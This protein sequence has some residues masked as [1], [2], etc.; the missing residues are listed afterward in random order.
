RG[1]EMPM[2][3]RFAV[4][5]AAFALLFACSAQAAWV[6]VEP[7]DAGFSVFFPAT[8]T[9]ATEQKPRVVTRI[10]NARAGKLICLIGVSDYDAHVEAERELELDMQNFLKQ[11][12]ATAT[13]Q[14][15]V[16]FRDA[17]DGPL[18]ALKFSFSKSG[19]TGQSLVVVAG[20]RSY[21]AAAI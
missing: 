8:P 13:S 17:P 6:K 14:E 3:S 20:D 11:T 10:W 19:Y 21:Q 4:A 18:P 12:Q 2:N 15:R 7:A 16:T 5:L 1:Y 9:S